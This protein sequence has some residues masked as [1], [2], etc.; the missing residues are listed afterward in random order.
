MQQTAAPTVGSFALVGGFEAITRGVTL[1][2]YPLVLYRAWGDAA[3][4][5]QIYLAVGIVS[6]ITVLIVPWLMRVV[7]RRWVHTSGV[8]LYLASA[9]FGMLGGKAVALALLCTVVGTAIAFVCYNANILQYVA[10]SE[11]GRL[12][13]LRLFYA[14]TGWAAGPFIGVWLLQYWHGAPFVVVLVSAGA[15]LAAIWWVGMGSTQRAHQ[16]GTV[17]PNPLRYLRR[18]AE[19]PRLVG[20]WL[21]VVIRSCGWSVFLVYVG[22]Y[23]IE[24][25]L[26]DRVGGLAA[27]LASTG[28]FLAPLMLRLMRSRPLRSTVRIGFFGSG[29]CFVLAA[30]LADWPW[31]SIVLLLAG[32]YFLVLLDLFGGLPFL[33]SVKPSERS[34][35]SAV[36]S[37]FR[38]AANIITPGAVWLVLQVGPLSSV[39]A[40]GGVGLLAAWWIAG[41][42]H[43]E[44]GMAPAERRRPDRRM[45]S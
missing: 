5:S 37:T 12:E 17:S 10:K 31:V 8:L 22:I 45:S 23:A 32:A 18:F 39:F 21:L 35:M 27:S 4:V 1:S 19:Q 6:L 20:A 38:D 7:P 15:M 25:G 40:V 42:M 41:R 2:V 28:L 13:T 33:M 16:M 36:Y 24:E 44:L 34:E 26:S 30:L 29:A 3:V 14:G 11:L 9:A 43:A